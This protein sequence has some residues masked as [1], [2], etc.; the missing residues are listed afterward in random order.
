MQWHTTHESMQLVK[1]Q[2]E[3]RQ[4]EAEMHR[5]AKAAREQRRQENEAEQEERRSSR[6]VRAL[7]RSIHPAK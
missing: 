4:H 7:T 6:L 2:Q 1:L 5:L 3:E